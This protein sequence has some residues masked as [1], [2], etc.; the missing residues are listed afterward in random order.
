M[1]IVAHPNHK[2][3]MLWQRP[4]IST[5][6]WIDIEPVIGEKI[7]ARIEREKGIRPRLRPLTAGL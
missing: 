7:V 3:E 2:A 1:V 5:N 4:S 6:H